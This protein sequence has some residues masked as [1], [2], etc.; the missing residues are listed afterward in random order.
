MLGPTV[1]KLVGVLTP[2]DLKQ[3]K[4]A[5]HAVEAGLLL[6]DL[7]DLVSSCRRTGSFGLVSKLGLMSYRL[8]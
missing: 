6:D 4:A 8:R 5:G 2:D 3:L 1:F 7:D